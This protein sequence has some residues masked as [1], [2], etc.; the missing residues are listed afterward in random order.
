MS[1]KNIGIDAEVKRQINNEGYEENAAVIIGNEDEIKNL[2]ERLDMK[3]YMGSIENCI[4][5][6]K[7]ILIPN[8]EMEKIFNKISEKEGSDFTAMAKGIFKELTPG[9][10][11]LFQTPKYI[12]INYIDENNNFAEVILRPEHINSVPELVEK[13]GGEYSRLDYLPIDNELNKL[14]FKK[15]NK[16]N[17]FIFRLI[18]QYKMTRQEEIEKDNE[19][20]R[21]EGFNF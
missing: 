7:E 3:G 4:R 20:R 14:G 15:S 16:Y 9:T 12:R 17:D 10:Y 2:R 11:F 19:Q 6:N 18:E 8:A 5:S 13:E 21:I 1:E